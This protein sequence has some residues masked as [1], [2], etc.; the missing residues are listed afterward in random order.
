MLSDKEKKIISQMLT[1]METGRHLLRTVDDWNELGIKRL[2]YFKISVLCSNALDS[3]N[4][5]KVCGG[6]YDPKLCETAMFVALSSNHDFFEMVK[7][8]V[9]DKRE[10]D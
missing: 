6:E 3:F 7:A 5:A 9:N 4:I 8:L 10:K 1:D 2:D